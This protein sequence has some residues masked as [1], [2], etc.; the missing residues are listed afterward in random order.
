MRIQTLL[1]GTFVCLVTVLSGRPAV[2][3]TLKL[4]WDASVGPDVTG[5][6]VGYRQ[7]SGTVDQI[8]DVGKVTAYTLRN[9]V[10]GGKYV[11][12]VWAYNSQRVQSVPAQITAVADVS[13][14]L[15]GGAPRI[16]PGQTATW[17]ASSRR[18][19]GTVEYLF[20]RYSPTTDWVTVRGWS[21]SGGYSWTPS[22]ANAGQYVLQVLARQVG[23][24]VSFEAQS[25]SAY[26]AVGAASL[27]VLPSRVDFD[28]DGRADL[29]VFRP[30]NGT[31]Y[32]TL[33]GTQYSGSLTRTW[34]VNT[35]LPVPGDYDGDGRTD[36]AVFRP[37]NGTWYALL[38]G[39]G[40]VKSIVRAWGASGDVPV[41]EDYDG[42][43]RTDLA[44]FRPANGTWY[45]L[46]STNGY[47][48]WSVRS[49]GSAT[50]LPVPADYDGDGRTDFAVFRPSTATW[51]VLLSS[52]GSKASF[53]RAWG[54]GT[55]RPAPAD[56]DG[57]GRADLAVFRPPTGTWYVLESSTGFGSILT[58]PWGAATD[59]AVPGDYDGDHRSDIAVFRP[60]TGTWL[61]WN[62]FSRAWGAPTDIPLSMK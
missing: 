44:V 46:H 23:S 38:S 59:V 8:V 50:D 35:D 29:G 37:S 24:N 16:A 55:D 36:I 13:V 26:F 20:R 60:S 57:D 21:T 34:G 52:T 42:D 12:S 32:A 41:P 31:W 6:L 10:T 27:M 53:V 49:W 25:S 15:A 3:A 39:G 11:L 5:Y 58:R 18:F 4:A 33:S 9:L 51:Y 14:N 45:A 22:R 30:G 54:M 28:G 17:N 43:G 7:T 48:S 62:Q 2:A 40:F 1:L 19:D 61:V 56:Y 47:A